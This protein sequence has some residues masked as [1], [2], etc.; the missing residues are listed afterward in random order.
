MGEIDFSEG[1]LIQYNGEYKNVLELPKEDSFY[2]V[3]DTRHEITR[4]SILGK[5]LSVNLVELL[6]SRKW[7]NVNHEI[8]AIEINNFL[9]DHLTRYRKV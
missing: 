6:K 9:N 1:I 7:N 4:A 2:L 5:D 3:N 8:K